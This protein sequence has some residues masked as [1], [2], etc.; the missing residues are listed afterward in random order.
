M[1]S[2]PTKRSLLVLLAL[3]LLM[4]RVESGSALLLTCKEREQKYQAAVAR[5]IESVATSAEFTNARYS[6]APF[7]WYLAEPLWNCETLTR[8]GEAIGDGAK[9]ICDFER[10]VKRGGADCLYYGFGVNGDV[11]FE[12][13]LTRRMNCRQKYAFDPTPSVTANSD[14]KG[15]VEA[16]QKL[17]VQF[18][19]IGL[20]DSDGDIVLEGQHVRAK[21]LDTI[22]ADLGHSHRAID[23][24]KIDVEGA[25]WNALLDVFAN[26]QRS[27]PLAH[28]VLVEVHGVSRTLLESLLA[29]ATRCGYR[30]FS[31]DPNAWDIRVYE[32]AFVHES[33]V[34]CRDE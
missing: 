25:E 2:L 3:V 14:G 20:S 24:L 30:L 11:A 32:L 4:L 31:K 15:S 19:P 6:Q 34:V 5:A 26:C 22:R 27:A 10:L 9:Y 16:L 23:I 18:M 28:Q 12:V 8:V 21:R 7:V 1:I 17:G 29:G 13:D 33:F